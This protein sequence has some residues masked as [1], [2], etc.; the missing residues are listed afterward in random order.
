MCL[1]GK[2]IGF[3]HRP[4]E[5]TAVVASTI[6]TLEAAGVTVVPVEL[7]YQDEVG[8]AELPAMWAEFRHDLEVYLTSRKGA[9]QTFAELIEFNNADPVELVSFGQDYFERAAE[10]RR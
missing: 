2:R 1:R 5:D 9:P 3:W 7:P 4:H 8:P 6:D 10:R